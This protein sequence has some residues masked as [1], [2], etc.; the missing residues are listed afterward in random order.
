M[1]FVMLHREQPSL[2]LAEN[3]KGT[4]SRLRKTTAG[5]Q[6][7]TKFPEAIEQNATDYIQEG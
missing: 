4:I 5:T 1:F 6:L 7:G 2:P 3:A